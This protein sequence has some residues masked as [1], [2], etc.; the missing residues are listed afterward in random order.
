MVPITAI[1]IAS[2]FLFFFLGGGEEIMNVPFLVGSSTSDSRLPYELGVWHAGS[3]STTLEITLVFLLGWTM[4]SPVGY[5]TMVDALGGLWF[6]MDDGS[7][8]ERGW[9]KR[10]ELILVGDGLFAGR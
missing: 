5:Y 1:L 2:F 10:P 8:V 3:Q 4:V 6:Y 7:L 9:C